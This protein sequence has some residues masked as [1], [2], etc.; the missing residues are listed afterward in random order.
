MKKIFPILMLLVSLLVAGCNKPIVVTDDMLSGSV[1]TGDVSTGAVLTGTLDAIAVVTLQ[2]VGTEP[3]WAFVMTG[4][5]MEWMAPGDTGVVTMIYTGIDQISNSG[6]STVYANLA[7]DIVLT[8][9]TGSCSD[10]MSDTVYPAAVGVLLSGM[11]YNG[12]IR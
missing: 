1:V 9:T 11:T 12:C 5:D 7:N 3:F 6:A 8:V 4:G 10:G 2:G